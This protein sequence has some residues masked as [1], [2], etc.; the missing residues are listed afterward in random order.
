MFANYGNGGK[1][2]GDFSSTYIGRHR[3]EGVHPD[4][5]QTKVYADW[6]CLARL[7]R[8]EHIDSA[9]KAAQ[10]TSTYRR[11]TASEKRRHMV[12]QL[13]RDAAYNTAPRHTARSV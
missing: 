7:P 12:Y 13:T 11:L 1:T 9:Q 3:W 6:C 2:T 10:P 5:E 4:Q 8:E